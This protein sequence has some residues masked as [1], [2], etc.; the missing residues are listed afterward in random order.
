[1]STQQDDKST[2][3]HCV[4]ERR[5]FL[6]ELSKISYSITRNWFTALL[7]RWFRGQKRVPVSRIRVYRLNDCDWVA[8]RTCDEAIQWYCLETGLPRD[9]AIDESSLQEC[10]LDRVRYFWD[11]D[12]SGEPTASLRG[13]IKVHAGGNLFPQVV[14]STEY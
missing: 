10:D 1:M 9:E 3:E 2:L 7:W 4:C 14:A 13:L 6:L 11:E 5:M 12:R 8:A